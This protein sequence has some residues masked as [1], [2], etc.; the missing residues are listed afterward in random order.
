MP[1]FLVFATDHPPHSM[2]LRDSVRAEHRAY[3]L[4]NDDRI[5]LAGLIAD[6]DGNQ[7]GSV[8]SFSAA[9]IDEV[10]AWLAA[11]PFVKAGV[12]ADIQV[13]RWSPKLN[14]LNPVE[15]AVSK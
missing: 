12:Y 2:P 13:V 6:D 8:Y 3:V 14:R 7:C 15:W 1:Q 5:M 9:N 10:K 11:E 4:E